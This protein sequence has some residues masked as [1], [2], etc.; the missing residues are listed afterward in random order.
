MPPAPL[1]SPLHHPAA[2]RPSRTDWRVALAWL[3]LL[4]AVLRGY[5]MLAQEP[6][7]ALANN[8]DQ[9]RY[10][11]CLDLYPDRPGVPPTQ[12][13][14]QA[15][16]RR[17]A[18]QYLP[19]QTC[20]W[21]SD[22]LFQGSTAAI[23]HIGEKVGAG[24]VH[25]V[26][27]LGR[28]RLIAWLLLGFALTR[29]FV[30]EGRGGLALAHNAALL[31]VG[32]DAVNA[33]YLNSFYAEGGALFFAW[34][35]VAL[36]V[37]ATLRPTPGRLAW[38]A[39]AAFGLGTAKLQHLVLPL[40]AVAALLLPAL[41]EPRLWPALGALLLGGLPALGVQLW[42]MQRANPMSEA[43]RLTNNTDTVLTALLPAS[44]DPARTAQRLGLD[45]RCA[46][47][48][49]KS[50]YILNEPA[51]QAC[52]GIGS[53]SRAKALGLALHE[54]LTLLHLAAMTP[55]QLLPWIPRYLGLVEDANLAPLPDKFVTLDRLFG[56]RAWLAWLALLLPALAY[57]VLLARV[58]ASAPARAF[59][60]LCASFALSVPLIGV[61]GD[62]MAEL[63]KHAHL[64]LSAGCAFGL[65]ALV[66]RLAREPR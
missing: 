28:L 8:F 59:A 52:P 14:H 56:E 34:L 47:V 19:G 21:T 11:A 44:D 41:R 25:S 36:A 39:L 27:L 40:C 54:P 42:Q 26:R 35:T 46:A 66:A 45:A 17:Y 16:L 65:C 6:L 24:P 13:N 62:G 50:I 49:G 5:A 3:L 53:F 55:K 38:L 48:S 29:A 31:A 20:Y 63:A 57:L 10:T 61:L 18:F 58:R 7:V 37:L 4:A 33:I 22:L 43:I 9:V 23:W 64:A 12:L 2:A 60:A 30:R 32:M 15:P 1:P 51:E